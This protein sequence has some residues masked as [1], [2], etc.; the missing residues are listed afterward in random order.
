MAQPPT[1]V[2][3]LLADGTTVEIRPAVPADFDA[4]KAMHEAMSSDNSYLR[5]F[6][7]S[8]HSAEIEARR[9]SR[10]PAPGSAALLAVANGEVVGVA[11]YVPPR[12]DPHTAALAFAVAD[13]MHHRGIATLLLEHLVS[14]A[15]SRRIT[16]FTAETLS[17]NQA[18]LGVFA[19]AGL[20]VR[21]RYNEGVI[22]LTFP[23]P[24]QEGQDRDS[25]LDA[26]AERE[27]SADVASLRHVFAPESVA[28]IGASRRRGTVGR[29]I[30]DNIRA[31]GYRGRLYVVN[32]RAAQVGGEPTLAS[33][34]DL[35]EPADLAVIAVP[36]AQV[37]E[38][39][40]QCGQRGVRS[41]VVITS[42]L[43]T[44]Q[45]AGLLATCRRHGMRLVGPDCF[46]V[47]VPGLG[48]D[49]T[50]AARPARPGVTGLVMQS[51]GL[52]FALVDHLSRLGIGISSFASV[53]DKLD[54]SGNDML[55]WWERDEQTRLAVLYLESFG[56]PRKFARTAR[57]VSCAMPVLTVLTD[58]VLTSTGLAEATPFQETLFE[59]AGIITT[60]GFGE[61]VQA[62]ALLA[63][64][65]VP[66]GRTVA[67]LSN[68]R[69][70]GQLAARA[71][72]SAGLRVRGPAET[73]APVQAG[74]FRERMEQLAAD[75][76]VHAVVAIV[77]PTGA[78]GDLEA[79]IRE[80][81]VAKP[82]AAVVLTQPESVRLIDNRI[83]AYGSP[84][85][86]VRAMAR[87]A[88]YGAWRAAPRGEV[89][90]LPGVRTADARA[91]VQAPG[92]LGPARAAELLACYGI[93]TADPHH[94]PRGPRGWWCGWSATGC[95]AAWSGW[96]REIHTERPGLLRSP[97]STPPTSPGRART[98]TCSTTCCCGCPGWPTTCPRSP[99]SSW[100]WT[101]WP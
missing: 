14:L 63:T 88:G 19:D 61:L 42:G 18:M 22:E 50:F 70:A 29:A 36:A 86:A 99:S 91:L 73:P 43:D 83:P 90:D 89:P 80:A 3:A 100:T 25:Y 49:A 98:S 57:R 17:D 53:G 26:V 62:A 38:V 7:I 47:A 5:F 23:L 92:W 79:A 4:V 21:R 1:A 59:Q 51:G 15:R 77:L 71:G 87:A 9:I 20:P 35:P 96:K 81:A 40:A 44:A 39:A 31:A 24:D 28:V 101:A 8:R 58:T 76:E 85:A 72:T 27:R 10:N 54:V 16:T 30:L 56:N 6:N 67:I 2:Y 60:G 69:T 64:Q 32:P 37:L 94:H 95:S 33:P 55:L 66:A 93:P 97:T 74:A 75:D 46:G 34:L 65:P 78:T 68:V 45:S 41:L 84:E 11:S 48:L 52:G 12:D 13:H 82:L